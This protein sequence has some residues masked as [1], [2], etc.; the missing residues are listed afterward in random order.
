MNE[1]QIDMHKVHHR[2]CRPGDFLINTRAAVNHYSSFVP[3]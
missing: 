2:T 1:R 3:R